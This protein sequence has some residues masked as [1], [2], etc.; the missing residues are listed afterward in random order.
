MIE[1]LHQFTAALTMHTFIKQS[2]YPSLSLPPLS[3]S[4]LTILTSLGHNL[5][6]PSCFSFQS[7]HK[8]KNEVNYKK[9]GIFKQIS[10]EVNNRITEDREKKRMN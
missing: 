3:L 7:L 8:E 2:D 5:T 9:C 10:E 6:N 4:L 1:E